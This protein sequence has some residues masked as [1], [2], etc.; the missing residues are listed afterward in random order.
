M[1]FLAIA[2]H[3]GSDGIDVLG[4]LKKLE[5]CGTVRGFVTQPRG[6]KGSFP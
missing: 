4:G 6:G 2:N 5:S 3:V 1:S